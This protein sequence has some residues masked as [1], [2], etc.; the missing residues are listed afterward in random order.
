MPNGVMI[1]DDAGAR[2]DPLPR[3]AV[4]RR[5]VIDEL[6]GAVESGGACAARRA[7]GARHARGVP[8]IARFRA[9]GA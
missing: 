2:L 5:E 7:L 8:R 3:P 1:Y 9:V 6:C 4:P